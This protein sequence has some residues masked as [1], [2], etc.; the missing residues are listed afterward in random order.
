MRILFFSH[1]FP[2]E[3][4]APASRTYE[5]AKRWVRDGHEVTVV[6]CAQNCPN[7]IVYEGYLNRP[8]H[9][10]MI[11][12]ICVVRVWTYI[13]PNEG[14]VRRIAN[15]LSYMVS[16]VLVSIFLKKPDVLIA[17]S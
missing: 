4:N 12:G 2:P 1:Y 5:N 6:T 7:G 10:E 11:D 13:A 8:Y 17:T 9:R 16:A 15:Y 3:G 14:T